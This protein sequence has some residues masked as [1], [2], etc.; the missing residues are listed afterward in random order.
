MLNNFLEYFGFVRICVLITFFNSIFFLKLKQINNTL[1]LIIVSVSMLTEIICTILTNLNK[2][3]VLAY[4]ISFLVHN[5]LW[6][7]MISK[8][9]MIK[10][11][12]RTFLVAFI[13]FSLI[14]MFFIEGVENLNN[15]IF[16]VGAFL[17][18]IMFIYESFYQLKKENFS[19]FLSN[20][21]LLLFSPILFFFGLSFAFAF[22][23]RLLLY[24]VVM[25]DIELYYF[26][27]YFV[28]FI[29]Y[30]LINIYIYREKKLKH[31]G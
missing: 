14:N 27:G 1:L 5:A 16:I 23:S 7:F 13:V 12:T 28:N 26:I 25:W 2:S 8:D 19:Y 11:A 20:H 3:I 18:L 6:L 17:Y 4:S 30:T 31:A 29:Y 9:I 24:T 15:N 21:Y 10:K 22:K